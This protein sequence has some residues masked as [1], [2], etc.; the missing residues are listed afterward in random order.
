MAATGTR[1]PLGMPMDAYRTED[2]SYHV[3]ADLP[4]VDPTASR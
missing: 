4:G 1:A 3:E 2:G